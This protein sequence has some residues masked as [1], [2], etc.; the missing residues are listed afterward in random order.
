MPSTECCTDS[1]TGLVKD[2]HPPEK[3]ARKVFDWISHPDVYTYTLTP[4]QRFVLELDWTKSPLGLISTWPTQLKD[5]VLLVMADP[6]PAVVYWGDEATIVYNEPYTQL[7]GSKHPSLQGQD[8][9]IGFAEIWDHF[10]ELLSKQRETGR[11]VLQSDA[12]LLLN[13]CGF[14]EETYFSWKFVPIIGP[15]GWVVGSHATVVEVTRQVIS[16]RRSETV[17]SL[18]RYL[19]ESSSIEQ[20]WTGIIKGYVFAAYTRI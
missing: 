19:S 4:F 18:S 10:E 16:D 13:R 9:K 3:K 11:T 12:L 5:M 20:L 1:P 2:S 14:L 7:I 15:E 6:T 17:R 8:P